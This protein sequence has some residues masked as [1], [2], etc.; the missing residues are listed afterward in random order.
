[1]DETE[2]TTLLDRA[3]IVTTAV[4]RD[5]VALN[6]PMDRI[7]YLSTLDGETQRLMALHKI[8]QD[9]EDTTGRSVPRPVVPDNE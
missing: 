2:R 7:R 4:L 3:A 6:D 9:V 5:V 8:G 1:M